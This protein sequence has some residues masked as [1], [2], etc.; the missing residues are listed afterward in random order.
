MSMILFS[1]RQGN[2]AT[3]KNPLYS[4]Y[5]KGT[6][7]KT[8]SFSPKRINDKEF[9]YRVLKMRRKET[10]YQKENFLTETGKRRNIYIYRKLWGLRMKRQAVFRRLPY[11]FL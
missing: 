8:L 6:I 7:G 3:V 9:Q 5:A 1:I 4:V 2:I 11:R 10:R